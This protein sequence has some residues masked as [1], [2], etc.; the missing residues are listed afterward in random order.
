M[1]QYHDVE[2]LLNRVLVAE[3]L[4]AATVFGFGAGTVGVLEKF[5]IGVIFGRRSF[6]RVLGL[7][8]L[9]VAPATA[10]SPPL[11]N[12]IFDRTGK[13]ENGSCARAPSSVSVFSAMNPVPRFR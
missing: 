2:A 12:A 8:N 7:F 1:Q 9:L 5:S 4:I 6:G 3:F 11:I 13:R 10:F